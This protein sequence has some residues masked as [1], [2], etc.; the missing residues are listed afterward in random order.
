MVV[1]A[2]VEGDHNHLLRGVWNESSL[3]FKYVS[4]AGGNGHRMWILLA[5]LTLSILAT[6]IKCLFRR[7]LEHF[8]PT[9]PWSFPKSQLLADDPSSKTRVVAYQH[10]NSAGR[11]WGWRTVS[12]DTAPGIT[13][14]CLDL[15]L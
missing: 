7:I 2:P 12:K 8:K 10:C 11:R 1:Q 5:E 15:N 4:S 6:G 3:G 14:R 13:L 9:S